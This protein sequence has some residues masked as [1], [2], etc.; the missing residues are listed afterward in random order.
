MTIKKEV[1]TSDVQNRKKIKRQKK[2]NNIYR[3]EN[4]KSTFSLDEVDNNIIG[5]YLDS[6]IRS[7]SDDVF[8]S[9]PKILFCCFLISAF[10]VQ[11]RIYDQSSIFTN[12]FKFGF[13]LFVGALLYFFILKPLIGFFFDFDKSQKFYSILGFI[14]ITYYF[15]IS[16]KQKITDSISSKPYFS[17]F[18]KEDS[19]TTKEDSSITL[20]VLEIIFI[21]FSLFF[22]GLFAPYFD[23][24][25]FNLWFKLILLKLF[26]LNFYATAFMYFVT[27]ISDFANQ[28]PFSP[29]SYWDMRTFR[30]SSN[31]TGCGFFNF[32][33]CISGET[34]I[35][36]S[37]QEIPITE[38][39]LGK[40]KIWLQNRFFP[41]PNS[42]TFLSR[43][44]F[45]GF[46]TFT[47]DPAIFLYEKSIKWVSEIS[48]SEQNS[49]FKKA[50]YGD[51][52]LRSIHNSQLFCNSNSFKNELYFLKN[53]EKTT[54]P[55][56]IVSS[57]R[58]INEIGQIELLNECTNIKE[59]QDANLKKYEAFKLCYIQENSEK[60]FN[61]NGFDFY[62]NQYQ[63]KLN[64]FFK[65][66]NLKRKR[67]LLSILGFDIEVLKFCNEDN[68]D[69]FD[70]NLIK[71]MIGI[72]TTFNG[73]KYP[74]DQ[75]RFDKIISNSN[76]IPEFD[77][78]TK[79]DS[80]TIGKSCCNSFYAGQTFSEEQIKENE[81]KY[82]YN[83]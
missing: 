74:G 41:D 32:G 72:K 47:I 17:F 5:E 1:I 40:F 59:T 39:S 83:L 33:T 78:T 29:L 63:D 69:K 28:E 67:Q 48:S 20:G 79:K 10:V 21:V 64:D 45:N 46:C 12:F 4:S 22:A 61:S 60:T 23:F 14:L 34:L 26:T 55:K 31:E 37:I 49:L 53:P 16:F 56:I 13:V 38:N 66:G 2:K 52:V 24:I 7:F 35:R 3:S 65:I 82:G 9:P 19:S 25:P 15:L 43:L 75:K 44:I 36:G 6:P 80:T 30:D 81:N 51:E 62:K 18:F 27:F 8:Y 68:D 70:K 57:Y 76:R 42:G 77:C 73:K 71:A 54:E 50:L 11:N 58:T